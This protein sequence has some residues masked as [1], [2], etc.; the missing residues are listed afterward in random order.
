MT[1]QVIILKI[2]L[3]ISFGAISILMLV[4]LKPL[5]QLFVEFKLNRFAMIL[6]GLMELILV[7][8]L[9]NLALDFYAAIG[10]AYLTTA[11]IYKHIK[12]RHHFK[13]YIPAILL[14][15]L[16]MYLALLL[17]SPI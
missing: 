16:S 2:V 9:F 12:A 6:T 8:L 3:A 17:L 1:E 5:T 14:L 15:I 13:N 7:W 10:L 4:G 11:A